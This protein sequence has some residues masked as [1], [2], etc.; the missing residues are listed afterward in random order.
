MITLHSTPPPTHTDCAEQFHKFILMQVLKLI[1]PN[2][3]TPPPAH[4]HEATTTM[5]AAAPALLDELYREVLLRTP[6]DDP[7]CLLRASIVCK[8]WGRAVSHPGFR[9]RLHELHGAPLLL[10]FLHDWEDHIPRFVPTTASSFPL[11]ALDRWFWR[12]LDCRH[13][14]ALFL[15][16]GLDTQEL[17]LCEPITGAHQRLPVPVSFGSNFPTAAVFC[18][19]DRCDHHDCFGGPFRVVFIFATRKTLSRGAPWSMSRRL[20]YTR[21]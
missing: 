21:R 3:S 18:A 12:A 5:A 13:G 1:E 6:P 11:A 19:A 4:T 10:G 16:Q 9:R 20:A 8:T 15:S 2:H 14:R 7:A 17:L